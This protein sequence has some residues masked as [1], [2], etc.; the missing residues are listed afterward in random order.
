MRRFRIQLAVLFVAIT[1]VFLTNCTK[2]EFDVPPIIVPDVEFEANTTI[3][4]LKA[5]Y[6][7]LKEIT[8]D[9]VIKGVITANDKSGNLYK[10]MIIQDETGAIELAIDQTNLSS[11][12]KVGQLLY[13]KCKGLYLGDYNNLI[14][15][16]Y[17]YEGGV[18]RMP[19]LM[20]EQHL[21]RDSLPGA[22]PVSDTV[23]ISSI[24]EAGSA[25]PYVSKLVTFKNVTFAEQ[26]ELYASQDMD[27]INR[28]LMD[29]TGKSLIVRNSKYA[30]FANDSIPYGYGTVTGILSIFGSDWQLT[31]RDVNDVVNFSDSM[32]PAPGSGEGTFEDPYNIERAM[33]S[34]GTNAVWVKGYIVG[35]YET[36][37]AD[38]VP[39]FDGPFETTS[40]FLIAASPDETAITNC[41]PVQLPSGAIRDAL[42][43]VD[44]ADNEGK[45]VMV[46]GTLAS[47]FSMPGIKEL[48]GYWLDGNGVVPATGF[49]TEEFNQ[50]IGS[51]TQYSVLGDQV[52]VGQD[53]DDGCVTMSGYVNPNR[54]PN[55]DWLISPSISLAGK[56][57]VK[58]IFREAMNY[59]GNI[60][61]EAKVFISTNYSGSGDPNEADWTELTGFTRSAGDSWGFVNTSEID[62]SAYQGQNIFIGFKYISTSSVAGTWE[63]SRVVVSASN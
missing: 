30:D 23:T 15:L 39:R 14:Q 27:A 58:M 20:I 34:T 11:L 2:N 5:S 17:L 53:Y 10:K 60:N 26:G 59:A 9:I 54:F 56:E 25:N 57:N 38:F 63:I 50:T 45:E 13:V 8:E 43:L 48:T 24:G 18:G 4:D 29:L 44:N 1:S 37:G 41:M 61:N 3:A 6:D 33:I 36:G 62:L 21:F 51:F 40:N 12:Y 49:F 52:W 55:E 19:E 28:T 16:G 46:L 35:V 42:N 7:G 47:Y 31:L 32:P 22:K